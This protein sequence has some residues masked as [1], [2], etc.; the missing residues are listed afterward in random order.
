M[1]RRARGGVSARTAARSPWRRCCS[2]A[3][4]SPWPPARRVRR[5]V[6]AA[7]HRRPEQPPGRARAIRRPGEAARGG[8][9]RGQLRLGGRSAGSRRGPRRDDDAG[10]R[11][12]GAR[13]RGRGGGCRRADPAARGTAG[14]RG[15]RPADRA[16]R[17]APRRR[18]RATAPGERRDGGHRVQLR[19]VRRHRRG[20]A[21]AWARAP[22]RRVAASPRS[23]WA[24]S[25]DR[26]SSPPFRCAASRSCS[27]AGPW[28]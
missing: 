4:R 15:G 13:R 5:R 17:A 3:R 21:S 25:P 26:C 9:G 14:R 11:P 8:L 16:R 1:G 28:P 24:T 27:R 18:A 20:P 2:A 19:R 22:G 7:A 10:R 12:A 6:R 23:G